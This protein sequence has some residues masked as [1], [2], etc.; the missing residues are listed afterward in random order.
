MGG[1]KLVKLFKPITCIYKFSTFY[2]I[3]KYSEGLCSIKDIPIIAGL[4]MIYDKHPACVQ[5]DVRDIGLS[6]DNM[7]GVF[8]IFIT[9]LL[10]TS[11]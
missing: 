3:S 2:G 6:Y 9:M 5:N 1:R 4:N 11:L 10:N 8:R 7:H